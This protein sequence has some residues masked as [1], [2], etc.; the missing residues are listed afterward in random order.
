MTEN[1]NASRS[2]VAAVDASRLQTAGQSVSVTVCFNQNCAPLFTAP[3]LV[4]TSIIGGVPYASA[5]SDVT[6]AQF[7]LTLTALVSSTATGSVQVR[8]MALQQ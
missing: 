2:G 7:T 8:W 6:T 4:T 3:P 1:A 5:V